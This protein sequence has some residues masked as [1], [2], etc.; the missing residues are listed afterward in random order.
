M[1]LHLGRSDRPDRIQP[2]AG[3][4]G[5]VTIA[6]LQPFLFGRSDWPRL[7]FV[8][9]RFE[10]ELSVRPTVE[11]LRVRPLTQVLVE[12]PALLERELFRHGG[13][14]TTPFAALNG[15]FAR[16]GA[17]VEVA[18]GATV[19]DPVHLVFV[20][21]EAARDVGL[22]PRLLILVGDGARAQLV[23]SYLTLTRAPAI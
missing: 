4:R 5:R 23:E 7:V 13:P 10:P 1:A 21:S 6:D 20:T 17:V 12:D 16:E 9:G 3:G 8:D 18:A 22:Y 14:G 11:G 19:V 15:A 2:R